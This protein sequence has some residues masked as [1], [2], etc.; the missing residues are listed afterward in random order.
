MI[1]RRTRVK[2]SRKL[3]RG[4]V[5][6]RERVHLLKSREREG[7]GRMANRYL[8]PWNFPGRLRS[9][10]CCNDAEGKIKKKKNFSKPRLK[11]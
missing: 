5:R 9:S 10:L 6:E 4:V 7:V 2:R 11:T 3:R 8:L 1:K